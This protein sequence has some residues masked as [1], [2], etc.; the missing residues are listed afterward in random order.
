MVIKPST[1][2]EAVS[3]CITN[4]FGL[5]QTR[6]RAEYDKFT[7]ILA[8]MPDK[9]WRVSRLWIGCGF[10]TAH[11]DS[12]G[13]LAAAE[14][15]TESESAS[16][17]ALSQRSVVP[18]QSR[19]WLRV[20]GGAGQRRASP[21]SG[22]IRGT[23]AL[24]SRHGFTWTAKKQHIDEWKQQI[25]YS[26]FCPVFVLRSTLFALIYCIT[27]MSI[28][29]STCNEHSVYKY[30]QNITGLVLNMKVILVSFINACYHNQTLF[31]IEDLEIVQAFCYAPHTFKAITSY[32]P[33]S[34]TITSRPHDKLRPL[35]LW[36][37]GAAATG[38]GSAGAMTGRR[39]SLMLR[40]TSG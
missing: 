10:G 25:V 37:W 40:V 11:R 36:H 29:I 35:T 33:R 17:S 31:S 4:E 5:E 28:G 16:E 8:L 38:W 6:N 1:L 23:S 30:E 34:Q 15:R 13:C 3:I 9:A 7:L 18:S 12:A 2:S 26:G 24:P 39:T 27:L 19:P 22:R 14:C 20:N 21:R 32:T